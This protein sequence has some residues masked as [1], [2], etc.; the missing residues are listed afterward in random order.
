MRSPIL[1]DLTDDL[2]P[3][4]FPF[5]EVNDLHELASFH[6][7]PRKSLLRSPTPSTSLTLSVLQNRFHPRKAVLDL[8][9]VMNCL[10]TLPVS[11]NEFIEHV[12]TPTS[13]STLSRPNSTS[14]MSTLSRT[15]STS[16]IQYSITTPRH[17]RLPVSTK[18]DKLPVYLQL[19]TLTPRSYQPV[20][21]KTPSNTP[22]LVAPIRRNTSRPWK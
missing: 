1:V 4:V 8:E 19:S 7:I 18:K 6:T 16:S 3:D 20:L 12:T 21:N 17:L 11:I 13:I 2:D 22:S 14:S 10:S 5:S 15:N 9:F